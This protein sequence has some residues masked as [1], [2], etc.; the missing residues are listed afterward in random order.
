GLIKYYE[1]ISKLEF[2]LIMYNV[3]SRTGMN[4]ELDTVNEIIKSNP[5]VFGIKESTT[6]INRIIKLH[7]ICKDQ[8]A[9]YSGEDNLNHIFYFLGS[10]GCISVTANILTREVKDIYRA[11]SLHNNNRMNELQ[12]SIQRINESLFLET[13]P[14]PIKNLLYK[15][16]LISSP[17]ARLPLVEISNKNEQII[18]SISNDLDLLTN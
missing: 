10:S 11:S 14:I 6:D 17:E 9:I 1:L 4:I 3:P 18:D 13:N 12:N 15:K 16:N 7:N 8:I 5:Y 2:P